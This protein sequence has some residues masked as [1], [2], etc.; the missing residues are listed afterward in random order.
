MCREI[1]LQPFSLV[2]KKHA[3]LVTDNVSPNEGKETLI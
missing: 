1:C 2:S 3:V